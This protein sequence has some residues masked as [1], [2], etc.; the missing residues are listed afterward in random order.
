MSVWSR[1]SR[2][3][4]RKPPLSP[5]TPKQKP[6]TI[7]VHGDITR[8]DEFGW[9]QRPENEGELEAYL[10]AETAYA[11]AEMRSTRRLQSRLVREMEQACYADRVPP[12]VETTNRGYSYYVRPGGHGS[13]ETLYCRRKLPDGSEQVLV[14]SGKL[15]RDEGLSVRHAAVSPDN[16][17]IACLTNSVHNEAGDESS[18]LQIYSLPMDGSR[19]SNIE[20]VDAVDDVINFVWSPTSR[21]VYYTAINAVLRADRVYVHRIATRSDLEEGP[22]DLLVYHEPDEQAFL[23]VSK[24]KDDTYIA[25]YSST[26]DSN[27][28]HVMPAAIDLF[29]L[30]KRGKPPPLQ[31]VKARQPGVEY[32]IDHIKQIAAII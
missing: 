19:V 29:E 4:V 15:E 26:L 10:R 22:R 5:P 17:L 8:R 32:F 13:G 2:S 9:M 23:D 24:T 12:P 27:Q 18:Q 14:D 25:I 20:L 21:D 28:V 7:T 6:S 30:A 3:L 1:L 11:L 31:L 16:R